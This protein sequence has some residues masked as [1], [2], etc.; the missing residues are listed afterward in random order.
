MVSEDA[1]HDPAS[2]TDLPY[3]YVDTIQTLDALFEDGDLL[4]LRVIP[5]SGVNIKNL[6]FTD[7]SQMITT[8]RKYDADT[9]IGGI[10]TVFNKI[11]PERIGD[12]SGTNKHDIIRRTKLVLD[13]DAIRA[14]GTPALSSSTEDEKKETVTRAGDCVEWLCANGISQHPMWGDSGNG[15]HVTYKIDLPVD[16]ESYDLINAVFGRLNKEGFDVDVT[17]KDAPRV[18]KLYGTMARKGDNTPERPHRRS[19]LL[20]APDPWEVVSK[21]QLVAIANTPH[22]SDITRIV[23]NTQKPPATMPDDLTGGRHP[24]LKTLVCSMV[25][26]HN[27]YSVILAACKAHNALFPIPKEASVLDNEVAKLYGWAVAEEAK[28]G[29]DYNREVATVESITI[30]DEAAIDF[31]KDEDFDISV[32]P[33]DN[34]IRMYVEYGMSIQDAYPEFHLANALTMVSYLAPAV[35]EMAYDNVWNN[36]W[37][38]VFGKAG[39][40]G[41]STT[42]SLLTTVYKK[43]VMLNKAEMLPNKVTPERLTQLMAENKTRLWVVDEAS[44]FMKNMKRDY[45]SENTEILLKIYSHT[46]VSKSTVEHTDRDGNVTGGGTI[47][48]EDPHVGMCWYTTPEMFAKHA[49]PDL[50][51][52]GFYMRPM[53]LLPMRAKDVMEDRGRTLDDAARFDAIVNSVN[54]LY[55]LTGGYTV[56]FTDNPIISKWKHGIRVAMSNDASISSTKGG[57][58]TRSFEHTRK[59][60]MLLTLASHQFLTYAKEHPPTAT[61]PLRYSI[62]DW[63]ANVAIAWSKK[64]YHNYER[65]V[66]LAANNNGGAF[67]TVIRL[68]ESAGGG[69][70]AKIE[71][72]DSIK[73]YGKR[74]DDI[75]QILLLEDVVEEKQVTQGGRGRPRTM[76]RIKNI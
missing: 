2:S 24:Q 64:F 6:F 22:D 17:M 69:W 66:F 56:K 14:P 74:W 5:K 65:A 33:D 73:M 47:R 49:S 68:L 35:M 55:S 61:S 72:Q 60:A 54:E 53:F 76:Y 50:F 28:K 70:V 25:A 10:Y 57:G 45:A 62:P 13:F 46:E 16:Q 59:L 67:Q 11:N 52:N 27:D 48:C 58:Q 29:V 32:L 71:L 37:L 43:I 44:G 31:K 23:I 34:L 40:S 21:E 18:C 15:T 36:V 63:A 20:S 75:S 38:F 8:V 42:Q 3:D 4:E 9:S 12:H 1:T 51:D 19:H 41:K 30:A 26:R 7:K 39:Q